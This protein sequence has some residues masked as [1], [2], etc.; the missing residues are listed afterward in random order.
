MTLKLTLFVYVFAEYFAGIRW[1]DN[2]IEVVGFDNKKMFV[3]CPV[4]DE[5]L[6]S[7]PNLVC[8]SEC[9][10]EGFLENAAA[11]VKQ[12]TIQVC[13]LI[14]S[15]VMIYSSIRKLLLVWFIHQLSLGYLCT[16]SK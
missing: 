1:D 12:L 10:G 15:M 14:C 4:W 3:G 6:Y 13:E 11:G 7:Y 9:K 5:K 16:T 2:C 8:I